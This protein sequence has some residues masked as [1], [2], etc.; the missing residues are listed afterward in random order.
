MTTPR[1]KK[2]DLEMTP[3]YHCVSR[4]VRRAF[5]YGKDFESNKDYSHRKTWL[6][7]RIKSQANIFA[8]NICAYAIMDNHYHLVLHVD[9][10]RA[11][12]WADDEV[13]TR[14]G[15][16][17]PHDANQLEGLSHD[18]ALRKLNLW[19][20]RLTSIS[21]FMRCINEYIARLSNAEDECTGRFWEGRFKSQA[22]LDEGAVLSAMAYVDLNPIRANIAKTPEE[23]EFTSIF[24]R[25]KLIHDQIKS[26]KIQTD[27]EPISAIELEKIWNTA[28]QPKYLMPFAANNANNNPII[29]FKLS[30]Y[31]QLVD[32]TGRLL[33]ENKKGTI[34][35]ML[36]PILSRIN[37]NHHT[38]LE[39]IKNLEENFFY[40]I[41]QPA[42]LLQFSNKNE[43]SK[44]RGI[45]AARKYYHQVA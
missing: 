31:I 29:D 19:R 4:C 12:S 42:M 43:T 20:E 8:I 34:P 2:I 7:N 44:P 39:M 14:W 37:L 40:S 35:N 21:W 24:E 9:A 33:R 16:L 22:L 32:T 36:P 45:S 25:I 26:Q 30:D 6:L 3:F 1:S 27:H 13:K 38:W 18:L 28:N 10:A 17:F 5:L 15:L 23:S 11:Q 41:G